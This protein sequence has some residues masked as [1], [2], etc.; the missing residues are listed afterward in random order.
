MLLGALDLLL[1]CFRGEETATATERLTC[2]PS[3]AISRQAGTRRAVASE[4]SCSCVSKNVRAS[5]SSSCAHADAEACLDPEGCLLA[6]LLACS[7]TCLLARLLVCTHCG[8]P[9]EPLFA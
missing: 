6:C 2:L 4:T 3:K 7:L 1:S 5:N 9:H 8:L